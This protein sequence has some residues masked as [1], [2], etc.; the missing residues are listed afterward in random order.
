VI[1]L[2]APQ[3]RPRFG[4]PYLGRLCVGH[5]RLGRSFPLRPAV[6]AWG[7]S[8]IAMIAALLVQRA[9]RC[10]PL[11]CSPGRQ[12]HS[13]YA[14]TDPTGGTAPTARCCM[15]STLTCTPS[16]VAWL[17]SAWRGLAWPLR[18]CC[19]CEQSWRRC[20]RPCRRSV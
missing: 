19:R 6:P 11:W 8:R 2:R 16:A 10:P 5:S 20:G 15:S 7:R 1:A 9:R 4:R 3:A 13:A 12:P 14:P 17:G 18:R